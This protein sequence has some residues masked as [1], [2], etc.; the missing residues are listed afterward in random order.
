[1]GRKILTGAIYALNLIVILCLIYFGFL[2]V[3]HNIDI[4]NPEAMLVM[5]GWDRGGMA[6]LMGA[7]PLF[8][9]NL[10][11]YLFAGKTDNKVRRIAFFIPSIIC[12]VLVVHYLLFSMT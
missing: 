8:V 6:L 9:T 11:A 3:S 7:I 5:E 1:M 2:Y 10:L 12:V 4:A